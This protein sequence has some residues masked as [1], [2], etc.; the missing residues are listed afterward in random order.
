[1]ATMLRYAHST[2]LQPSVR[3]DFPPWIA[4][5]P[6]AKIVTANA[7][8]VGWQPTNV[9]DMRSYKIELESTASVAD[10]AAFYKETLIRNGFTIVSE[11]KSHAITY[12]LEA[13][14][15]DRMHQVYLDILKRA[16][17]TGVRLMDHVI[18]EDIGL[19]I[20]IRRLQRRSQ[21]PCTEDRGGA[22]WNARRRTDIAGGGRL[23]TIERIVYG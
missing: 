23:G 13:R 18:Q 2:A 1:M 6:N 8:P 3:A 17:D 11:T 4:F 16:K 15:A 22:N 5:Y 10:I 7:P 9:T 19:R 20:D 21:R 12:A 14:S